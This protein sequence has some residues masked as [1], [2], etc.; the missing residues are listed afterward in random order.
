MILQVLGLFF[1]LIAISLGLMSGVCIVCFRHEDIERKER[2]MS[3]AGFLKRPHDYLRKPFGGLS[4]GMGLLAVI[5]AIAGVVM[6]LLSVA[7]PG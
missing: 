7:Y 1:L 5:S 4:W 3:F 2:R 6:L